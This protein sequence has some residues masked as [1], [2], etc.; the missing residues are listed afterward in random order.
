MK[1]IFVLSVL[2]L[3]LCSCGYA[4]DDKMIEAK[5]IIKQ[6]NKGKNIQLVDKIISDDLDFTKIED[7]CADAN[8]SMQHSVKPEILFVKCVFLGKVTCSSREGK[9]SHQARFD[10]NL[11]FRACDF[12]NTVD[13]NY[14]SIGGSLNLAQSVFR[15]NADLN[16]IFVKGSGVQL[17]EVKAEKGFSMVD[18][19]TL[20]GVN[21]MDAQFKQNCMLQSMQCTNL[22]FS[23]VV[24]E[25][26]LDLSMSNVKGR[27]LI[28]YGQFSGSVLMNNVHMEE[29]D[30]LSC[31]FGKELQLD[32]SVILGKSR[33]NQSQFEGLSTNNC[34]FLIEPLFEGSNIKNAVKVNVLE[35]KQIEIK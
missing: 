31:K 29:L 12:R 7:R 11:S 16:S 5:D 26:L 20:G 13:F 9:I 14:T 15:E 32:E 25:S 4:K 19:R 21:M 34:Y 18:L 3:F 22:Q 8:G 30:M 35:S 33:F 10:N 27:A 1:K 17:W 2:S 6:I 23:N 24:C 28:N